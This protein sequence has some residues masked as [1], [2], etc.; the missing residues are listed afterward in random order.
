[1]A[2]TT[3]AG[4]AMRAITRANPLAASLACRWLPVA[5]HVASGTS[6]NSAAHTRTV[7]NRVSM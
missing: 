5:N 6:A 4:T 3:S 2:V 7:F 1:M